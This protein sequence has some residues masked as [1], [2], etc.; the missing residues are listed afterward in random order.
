[1][2][3]RSDDDGGPP[4]ATDELL[5]LTARR[6]AVTARYKYF[7]SVVGLIAGMI[8]LTITTGELWKNRAK[9][10]VEADCEPKVVHHVVHLPYFE[11][12]TT[13][14]LRGD[15]LP[16]VAPQPDGLDLDALE[17]RG[18]WDSLVEPRPAEVE[19][20]PRWL[21]GLVG[22]ALALVLWS[23]ARVFAGRGRG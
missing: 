6:E 15:D 13:Q 8:T 11:E 7:G 9:A 20:A 12:L 23:L 22:A 2:S 19:P 10:E 17:K 1:M 18:R 16:G 3:N 21:L 5:A 4:A 14:L